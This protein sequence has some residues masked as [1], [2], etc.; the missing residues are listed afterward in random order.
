MDKIKPSTYFALLMEFG[1]AHVPVTVFAKKYM[2]M[3]EDWA[4]KMATA[5]KFPINVFRIG[6]Q[7]SPWMIDIKD[8]ADYI[9]AEVEKAK[10]ERR[11]AS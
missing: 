2:D 1:T 8:A 5:N 7:K 9:D 10:K 3:E 4:K 6:G 11:L